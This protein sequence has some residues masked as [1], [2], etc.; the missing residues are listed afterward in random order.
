M[1]HQI[2]IIRAFNQST[3]LGYLSGNLNHEALVRFDSHQ[4]DGGKTLAVGEPVS[5]ELIQQPKQ[6]HAEHIQRTAGILGGY[7]GLGGLYS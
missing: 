7:Q 3:G 5:Y 1:S 6:A 2:G 4:T